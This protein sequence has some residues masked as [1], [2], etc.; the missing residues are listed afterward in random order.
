MHLSFDVTLPNKISIQVTEDYEGD[1]FHV[2]AFEPTTDDCP[3]E[4][5]A[6]RGFETPA[7]VFEYLRQLS[8]VSFDE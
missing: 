2:V 4:H 1:R 5:Y 6:T 3:A 7:Q 8:E